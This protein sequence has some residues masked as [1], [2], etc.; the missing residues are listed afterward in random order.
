[1]SLVLIL[2]NP[3]DLPLSLSHLHHGPE[4]TFPRR[5]VVFQ[6]LVR[7]MQEGAIDEQAV[8]HHGERPPDHL[9]VYRKQMHLWFIIYVHEIG[10][11]ASVR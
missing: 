1:M 7:V 6:H 9:R 11:Y 8:D 3:K 2:Q 5:H 10:P 4:H